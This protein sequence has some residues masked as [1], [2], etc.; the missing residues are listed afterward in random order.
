[1]K[2]FKHILLLLAIVLQLP[3]VAFSQDYKA[4]IQQFR[5]EQVKGLLADS[6]KFFAKTDIRYLRYF[7]PNPAYKV[8]ATFDPT[9][10]ARPFLIPTH[11]GKNKPFKEYG[12]FTFVLRDTTYTLH[13]YQNIDLINDNAHKDDLFVPFNDETNYA[14]TYAGGRYIDLSIKDI[15]NGQVVIDFNKCYNPYCAYGEGFSCPIPPDD[16]HLR[17]SISAG[18]KMF[19]KHMAE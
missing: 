9:P 10:G 14:Q 3:A 16:N 18:E 7:E 12:T 1:M 6:R 8:V 4:E 17:T 15:N 2:S 13:A 5:D 19:A 11:S